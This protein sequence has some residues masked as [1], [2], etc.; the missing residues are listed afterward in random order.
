[1]PEDYTTRELG[2]MVAEMKSDTKEGLERIEGK[3]DY[4]NGSIR[5]LQ[6]WRA[7]MLGIGSLAIISGSIIIGLLLGRIAD[8]ES[9]INN[10]IDSKINMAIEEYDSQN[11]VK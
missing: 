7:Y 6:L 1:M 4:T 8:F 5:S 3:V 2:I 9:R 10:T 11:F